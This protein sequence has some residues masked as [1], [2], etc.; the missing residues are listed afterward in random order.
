MCTERCFFPTIP[1]RSQRFATACPNDYGASI[2][3]HYEQ[4]NAVIGQ[5]RCRFPFVVHLL[6]NTQN[7]QTG[8]SCGTCYML[9][10]SRSEWQKNSF[11]LL[12]IVQSQIS[13]NQI[14]A[15]TWGAFKYYKTGVLIY[16]SVVN[17]SYA[18]AHR[19]KSFQILS[20]PFFI[21]LFVA[22]KT[23]VHLTSFQN[24]HLKWRV[25]HLKQNQLCRFLNLHHE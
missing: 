18:Q 11:T 15:I 3:T 16:W 12:S 7:K 19:V 4:L 9:I 2:H 10:N 21:I 5:R 22:Q 13:F 14:N 25:V 24:E 23:I 17:S 6:K 8:K 20:Y 1:G